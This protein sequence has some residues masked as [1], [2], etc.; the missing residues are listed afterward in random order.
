MKV[1]QTA[2]VTLDFLK[3]MICGILVA[4]MLHAGELSFL[5]RVEVDLCVYSV[6]GGGGDA[7]R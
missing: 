1:V 4:I 7:P 6:P 5:G 3:V 2:R